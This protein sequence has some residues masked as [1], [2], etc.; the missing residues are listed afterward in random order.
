MTYAPNRLPMKEFASGARSFIGV[1]QDAFLRDEDLTNDLDAVLGASA[2][3]TGLAGA[4]SQLRQRRK[5]FSWRPPRPGSETVAEVGRRVTRLDRILVR[6][7]GIAREREWKPPYP[8]VAEA[9]ALAEGVRAKQQRPVG[10]LVADRDHLRRLA[11][12]ASGLLDLL[13][14]DEGVGE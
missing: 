4:K 14:D 13:A 11:M 12:A 2:G 8:D 6:L 1:L 10:E 9:I 3:P 7:V 5:V